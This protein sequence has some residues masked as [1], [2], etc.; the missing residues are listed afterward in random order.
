MAKVRTLD[1]QVAP[2]AVP[3]VRGSS[4]A[5]AA[6]FGGAQAADLKDL[7]S[8]LVS[9]GDGVTKAAAVYTV[10]SQDRKDKA[11]VRDNLNQAEDEMRRL[12]GDLRRPENRERAID[13]YSH[14]QKDF[15]ETRKKYLNA[16]GNDRQREL[17]TA[18]FDSQMNGALD[19]AYALQETSRVQYEKITRDAQNQSAVENA[20]AART[21]PKEIL[22]S[23]LTIIAN[24][25][26]E[27]AGLPKDVV[28]ASV[29]MAKNNLH[30]SVVNALV[31]E[32]PVMAQ[33]YLEQYKDKFNPT[34]YEALKTDTDQKAFDWT[35]RTTADKLISTGM[36]EQ[37]IEAAVAEVKDPKKADALRAR[38]KDGLEL[39]NVARDIAQKETIYSEWNNVMKG[40]PVPYGRI[41]G[42]E[43]K[44]METYKKAEFAGFAP[45]SDRGILMQLGRL[46]DQQ[47]K[48]VD[49]VTMAGYGKSLN[50]D[51]FNV[52]FNRYR[53]LRRGSQVGIEPEK[54]TQIR[55]D[56]AMV[57]DALKAVGIDPGKSTKFRKLKQAEENAADQLIVNDLSRSFEREIN[58]AQ[59]AK[60]RKLYPEEKQQ[61]L[62]GL[63][64]KGKVRKGLSNRDTYVF[65]ADEA[66][67]NEK[68]FSIKEIPAGIQE[69]MNEAFKLRGIAPTPDN[70]KNYYLQY[71]RS[72]KK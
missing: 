9:A 28:N 41:S 11:L 57:G 4:N 38:I 46:S 35:V 66:D 21:D 50:R 52:I 54:L 69:Q 47:L 24:T 59:L 42:S 14:A 33:K 23:E 36:N 32:D 44:A 68:N 43:V 27:N 37:Q 12:E 31:Q 71:L 3:N 8:S 5:S 7:G 30:T 60:G 18:S 55:T 40:G 53:E 29:A 56:S 2:A 65:Q 63:M 16:L 22:N 45:E 48:E 13:A 17:F 49:E 6:S 10:Q 67:I 34:S 25:R 64:I 19:R 20:V 72:K 61:I 26:A 58:D 39:R 15:N 51:D 1:P 70:I 62:D